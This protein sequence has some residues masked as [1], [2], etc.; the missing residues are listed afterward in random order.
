AG[1]SYSPYINTSRYQLSSQ[2]AGPPLNLEAATRPM[3]S[4]DERIGND[5]ASRSDEFLLLQRSGP[6]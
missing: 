3:S 6:A 5:L 2:G 4:S 1:L